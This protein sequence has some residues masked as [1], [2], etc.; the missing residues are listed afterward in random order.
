MRRKHY[1]MACDRAGLFFRRVVGC[2]SLA[3]FAPLFCASV[4]PRLRYAYYLLCKLV[5]TLSS[6]LS[7]TLSI[8]ASCAFNRSSIAASAASSLCTF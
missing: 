5:E 4:D 1:L 7:F 2:L 8:F 3:R 6:T